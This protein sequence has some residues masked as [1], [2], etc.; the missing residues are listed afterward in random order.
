MITKLASHATGIA[1][2]AIHRAAAPPA[3]IQARSCSLGNASMRAAPPSTTLTSPLR[4]AKSVTGVAMPV[5]GLSEQT[6]CNAWTAMFS[7]TV[8][9]WSSAHHSTTGTPAPVSAVTATVS[10]ARAPTSAHAAKSHFF[11]SEPSVFRNVRKDTLQTMPNTNAQPA[12]RDAC[13]AATKIGVTYAT[14]VSS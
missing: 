10:S 8:C 3:E 4:L 6:A 5:P 7:R 2:A 14:T 12:L 1:E 11:S 9:A 13:S